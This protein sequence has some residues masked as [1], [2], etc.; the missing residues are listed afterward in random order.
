MRP[1]PMVLPRG[2]S[3]VRVSAF[4]DDD[5]SDSESYNSYRLPVRPRAPISPPPPDAPS[6]YNVKAGDHEKA[7]YE[8]WIIHYFPRRRI[9][10]DGRKVLGIQATEYFEERAGRTVVHPQPS[11]QAELADAH[12]RAIEDFQAKRKRCLA[13]RAF[14]GSGKTYEQDL[15]ERCRGL[16]QVVKTAT[17]NLLLDRERATSTR[18]RTRTWTVVAMREQLRQRFA[19]P[20]FVELKRHK[21]R[22]WKNPSREEPLVYTLLI[23]GAATGP[24]DA[25]DVYTTTPLY[26][27]WRFADRVEL[28]R[29]SR[30]RSLQRE[31]L[32]PKTRETSPSTTRSVSPPPYRRSVRSLDRSR[33]PPPYRGGQARSLT[34]SISPR[35]Y[36]SPIRSRSPSVRVRVRPRV[37]HR[38]EDMAAPTPPESYTPPPSVSA[39]GRPPPGPMPFASNSHGPFQPHHRP[40]SWIQAPVHPPR[41]P[42]P[43][44]SFRTYCPPEDCIGCQGTPQCLHFTRPYICCRPVMWIRGVPSHPPCPFCSPNSL[45]SPPPPPPPPPVVPLEHLNLAMPPPTFPPPPPRLSPLT[46]PTLSSPS[47]T[48]PPPFPEL[49]TPSPSHPVA[50]PEAR[51][52]SRP[53]S[54]VDSRPDARSESPVPSLPPYDGHER[55]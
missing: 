14:G 7:V 5:S 27:P 35:R 43:R 25:G 55:E 2:R 41:P 39:Y 54:P 44:S 53:G 20:D 24:T 29:R 30:E 50:A 36:D 13:I 11:T 37:S 42:M 31:S 46:T 6:Y 9:V 17:T 47:S 26:N 45:A 48:S 32:R 23:R 3:P 16:P 40:G 4:A 34:R 38:S 51:R 19:E 28:R 1:A 52:E 12:L 49:R 33:S 22:F 18:Y 10:T 15:Q 21:L 8:A